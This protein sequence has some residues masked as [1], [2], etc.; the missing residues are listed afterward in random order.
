MVGLMCGGGAVLA[1]SIN[2]ALHA[3]FSD[4]QLA[5]YGGLGALTFGA[6]VTQKETSI[7][8]LALV[9][10]LWMATGDQRRT[11][12]HLPRRTRRTVWIILAT[13]AL[14]LVPMTARTIQLTL[15]HPVSTTQ[16]PERD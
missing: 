14:P 9:P 10:F 5:V 12:A 15:P 13:A 2:R 1:A 6:G 16:R 11:F 7:C 8:I 4:T 3:A